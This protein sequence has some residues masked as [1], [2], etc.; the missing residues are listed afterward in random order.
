MEFREFEVRKVDEELRQVSGLAVPY[1]QAVNVGDY[2]EQ[3][4]RGAFGEPE[5]VALFY[6]HNHR[7][8]GMPIG[9]VTAFRDTDEGLE[10]D[11]VISKTQQ[12][13]EVYTLLRDGTL[14]R[15]SVGFEPIEQKFSEDRST[16]IRTKALLRE[17]SIVPM[18]AYEQAKVAQVRD[19]QNTKEDIKLSNNEV[20]TSEAV[21]VEAR[22]RID[23]LE[24]KVAGYTPVATTNEGS[25][26]RSAAELVKA[27]AAGD[28]KAK[29]EIRAYTGATSADSVQRNDWKSSLLTIVNDGRPLLNLFNKGPL[30]ATGNTVE[31]PKIAALT[32]SVN[33]QGAEGD[34]LAYIE[35]EIDTATAPVL[36]YGGYSEISRQAIERSDVPYL[37]KVLEY[38]ASTYAS[39]TNDVVVDAVEGASAQTGNSFTLSS[40][41]AANFIG[42]AVTGRKLIKANAK[43]ARAE[44]VLVSVDVWEKM[45]TLVDSAGRPI[46]D[47]NGDGANTVGN[48]RV[49]DAVG[50]LVGLPLVMDES[51]AAKSLY[52]ASSDAVTTWESA[53]A[54]VRLQD[55]NIIN[56]TK[57]FSLY[58][59][60][61]V[62]VTNELALVKSTV[63]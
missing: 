60:M 23:D 42:A 48:I 40:A 41:T 57:Q 5:N 9:K 15:F 19:T 21:D 43:G 38:Q 33:S 32:G 36:T 8:G 6:G 10:I 7:N 55:E 58:G 29:V 17:V 4:E 50:R 37:Q 13:D 53:G 47:L 16:V 56:L 25:Q 61:A 2:K 14:N 11:A 1:G 35:V 26:F 52:V 28:E 54:P 49:P 18:P 20:K 45:A 44:F 46:F 31:Y 3:I 59:Y 63:A 12:G 51:L 34:D 62:G 30:G 27:L 24:R 39:K 22:D